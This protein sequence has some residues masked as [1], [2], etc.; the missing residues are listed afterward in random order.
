M[1]EQTA[2]WQ[3]KAIRCGNR[4]ASDDGRDGKRRERQLELEGE[5][6]TSKVHMF[7]GKNRG[8]KKWQRAESEGERIVLNVYAALQP[9]HGKC[10]NHSK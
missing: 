10:A 5:V 1:Q 9:M 7:G 2:S 6:F 4:V 3:R 8:A